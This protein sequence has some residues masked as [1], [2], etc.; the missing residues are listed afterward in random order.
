MFVLRNITNQ[1]KG[2][3]MNFELGKS[4]TLSIEE[5]DPNFL[6][7]RK[8]RED[9]NNIWGYVH[10]DD[11]CH[12]LSVNQV[13]YIMTGEGKTFYHLK[14][15]DMGAQII[16]EEK[17]YWQVERLRFI[18]LLQKSIEAINTEVDHNKKWVSIS[19]TFRELSSEQAK[20]SV[21]KIFT[22]NQNPNNGFSNSHD[23]EALNEL[24]HTVSKLETDWIMIYPRFINTGESSAQSYKFK[25]V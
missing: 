8:T 11:C 19:G 3:Q 24:I 14:S 7:F 23:K 17:E 4:Y 2:V 20:Q 15:P 22:G 25:E 18:D 13:S 12:Q 6:E 1:G 9:G 16:D 10:G 5:T 21:G